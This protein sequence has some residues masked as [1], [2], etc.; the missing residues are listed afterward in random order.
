MNRI[1]DTSARW[2]RRHILGRP[3]IVMICLAAALAVLGYQ[4]RHF[5]VDAS[6]ETLLLEN[7]ADLRYSRLINSRYGIN[8]FLVIAYRPNDGDLFSE[9][10]RRR[11]R[12][13]S[14]ELAV[15]PPVSGG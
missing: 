13:L 10:T 15:L 6:A 4:A 12:K 7:D 14:D 2:Y 8:D 3:G 1:A 5:K 9:K 11:L